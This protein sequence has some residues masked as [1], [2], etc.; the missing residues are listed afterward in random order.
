MQNGRH[1]VTQFRGRSHRAKAEEN[2]LGVF[3]PSASSVAP[4]PSFDVRHMFENGDKC[5]VESTEQQIRRSSYVD[6][7]CC[8]TPIDRV[9]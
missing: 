4:S 3:V 7:Q 2:L 6:L 1:N 5:S 8:K 9:Q